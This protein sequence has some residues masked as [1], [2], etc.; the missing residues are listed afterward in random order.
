MKNA[1]GIKRRRREEY[2]YML[3][4]GVVCRH[5]YALIRGNSD[6]QTYFQFILKTPLFKSSANATKSEGDR[7]R[8]ERRGVRIDEEASGGGWASPR[9]PEGHPGHKSRTVAVWVLLFAGLVI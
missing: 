4:S 1:L 8:C 9:L 5:T 2:L 3:R 6:V 7:S